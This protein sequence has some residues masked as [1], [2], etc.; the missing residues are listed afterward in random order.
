MARYIELDAL[1]AEMERRRDAALMRQQNLESI[2]QE[3]VINEMVANELNRIISFT[4][5]LE[6]KEVDLDALGILAEHLLACDAHGV[7]PNYSGGEL[8]LLE[9]LKN[10]KAQKG[11]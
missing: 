9:E 10:N 1:L 11:E 6:V 8:D 4:D 7:S 3:S 5:T 2:G